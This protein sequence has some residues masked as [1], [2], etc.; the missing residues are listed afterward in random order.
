MAFAVEAALSFDGNVWALF[1]L[2]VESAVVSAAAEQ[3]GIALQVLLL[4][5]KEIAAI[6]V[7]PSPLK[8]PETYCKGT[9][10]VSA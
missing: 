5:G 2:L 6:S 4:Y 3:P 8:S 1:V 7:N 10:Y 9:L